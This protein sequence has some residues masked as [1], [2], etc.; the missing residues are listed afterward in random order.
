M[1]GTVFQ[2]LRDLLGNPKRQLSPDTKVKERGSAMIELAL[3]A[4]ILTMLVIG[5]AEF[6]RFSYMSIEIAS[7]AR[8]GVQYGAQNHITASNTTAMQ[9]AATADAANVP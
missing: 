4:P 2:N 7:A 1:S 9:N 8:A 3:V 6:G 5:V